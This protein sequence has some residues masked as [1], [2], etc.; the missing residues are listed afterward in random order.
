MPSSAHFFF[1]HITSNGYS[2]TI[3]LIKEYVDGMERQTGD[4]AT[5]PIAVDLKVLKSWL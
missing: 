1:F 2:A 5:D 4:C 3:C